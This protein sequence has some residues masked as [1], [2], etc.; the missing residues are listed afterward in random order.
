MKERE[1][2]VPQDQDLIR[3][4]ANNAAVL[5]RSIASELQQL[6]GWRSATARL[7]LMGN[8]KTRKKGNFKPLE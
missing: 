3:S 1:K 2:Y 7:N 8:N 4:A 5:M 6:A